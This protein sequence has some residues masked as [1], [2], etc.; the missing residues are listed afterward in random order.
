M[1]NYFKEDCVEYLL[2]ENEINLLREVLTSFCFHNNKIEDKV[3]LKFKDLIFKITNKQEKRKII[4]YRYFSD[5]LIE[6]NEFDFKDN[7]FMALW[8]L[9]IKEI[10]IDSLEFQGVN[11]FLGINEK[12]AFFVSQPKE[13][14]WWVRFSSIKL[15]IARQF[16]QILKNKYKL[17]NLTTNIYKKTR[18]TA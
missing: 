17:Y 6:G 11:G 5:F 2:Q 10:R 18:R 12:M 7:L 13:N 1:L 3:F 9:D 15:N 8:N 16:L 4:F 14:L